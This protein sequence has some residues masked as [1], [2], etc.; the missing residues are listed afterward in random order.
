MALFAFHQTSEPG[1]LRLY[2]AVWDADPAGL[3]A[4]WRNS[5]VSGV[6]KMGFYVK[7]KVVTKAK[8]KKS[9]VTTDVTTEEST[10][11]PGYEHVGEENGSPV[12]NDTTG[13]GQAT[14]G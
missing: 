13:A 1:V 3:L 6:L 11:V 4:R 8:R 10:L 14:N 7:H 5:M 12:S 2:R 9:I